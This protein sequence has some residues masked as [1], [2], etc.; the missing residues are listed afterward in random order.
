MITSLRLWDDPEVYLVASGAAGLGFSHPSDSNTYLVR[1]GHEALLVDAG[2]T[3]DA[4]VRVQQVCEDLGVRVKWLFLTHGHAD[5]AGGV[6]SIRRVCCDIHV[7]AGPTLVKRWDE[8]PDPVSLER[9]KRA[10]IYPSDFVLERPIID[11]ELT[12]GETFAL[13]TLEVQ[14]L[15][16]PGHTP[17]HMVYVLTSQRG[18]RFLFSGDHVFPGGHVAIEP[19]PGCDVA[20]YADSMRML[21]GI[22]YSALFAGHLQPALN[23]RGNSI[24]KAMNRFDT[25]WLPRNLGE[26]LA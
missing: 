2:S 19:I 26:V 8:E 6:E 24:R 21:E 14:A 7:F 16:T 11:R 4:G 23:D 3:C 17:E 18:T 12:G 9:A 13:N 15:H 20:A 25:L 1:D 5:H 10:G 22:N